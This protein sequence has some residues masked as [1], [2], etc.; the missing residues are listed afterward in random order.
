M[1]PAI[2]CACTLAL[3]AIVPLKVF[4]NQRDIVINEILAD[5][6]VESTGEYIELYNR[7]DE[8]ID[9]G[10]WR[11]ADRS[12]INDVITDYQ[13]AFDGGVAGTIVPPRGYALIVDPDYDGVYTQEYIEPIGRDDLVLLTISGDRTI[14]NGL[15]NSGDMVVLDN[16]AGYVVSFTWPRA[17]GKAGQS[18]EK[19]DVA[20]DD[21]IENWLPARS[22]QF[23]TPGNRN[24]VAPARR[25]IA[26]LTDSIQTL[27][28]EL[29]PGESTVTSCEVI[30]V[31]TDSLYSVAVT[32]HLNPI[33]GTTEVYPTLLG[34]FTIGP[35]APG[36][37]REIIAP[38]RVPFSGVLE[39]SI[40]AT[41]DGDEHPDNDRGVFTLLVPYGSQEVV[42]NEFMF[43]PVDE[44]AEWIELFNRSGAPVDLRNWSIETADSTKR[45]IISET[46]ALLPVDG[47]W[48]LAE[49]TA[50]LYDRFPASP[51]TAVEPEGAWPSLLNSGTF[52][53]IRDPTGKI[54]DRVSYDREWSETAGQAV[55]RIHPDLATE[56][57]RSWGPSSSSEG[58]TPGARN[59]LYSEKPPRILT[60][61]A[62]PNPFSPDGDGR[63][64]TVEIRVSSPYARS[65][66]RIRIYDS[67]GRLVKNLADEKQVGTVWSI[68]WDG[69][70][71]L[72]LP[73]RIGPYILLLETRDPFEGIYHSEKKV[74]ILAGTL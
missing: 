61:E 70:T 42:V 25:D 69:Q 7:G 34:R 39:L 50:R 28:M 57:E 6:L 12:D 62:S 24:S 56:G 41:V 17:A 13:G 55:E 53:T 59:S 72:G 10:G 52:I 16:G 14:G 20:G 73:G 66:I 3:V 2:S 8:P 15:G 58:G 4:A 71:D 51:P 47:Y 44:Q 27:P 36:S 60:I 31:G 38:W 5:P 30:N 29:I 9:V 37:T 74:I 45:R 35:L 67:A 46:S 18:W 22:D 19:I 11:L 65:L 68:S 32:F 43:D 63:E 21:A 48:V 26:L 49:N 1:N 33:G 40:A 23:R 54:I 64:D